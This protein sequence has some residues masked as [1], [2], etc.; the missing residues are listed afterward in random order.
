VLVSLPCDKPCVLPLAG[1]AWHFEALLPIVLFCAAL[2][3]FFHLLLIVVAWH[4]HVCFVL[5]VFFADLL[6]F[7]DSVLRTLLPTNVLSQFLLISI[8]LF[9]PSDA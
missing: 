1:R 2:V 3:S 8:S 4:L 9:P 6:V 7:Y 5:L